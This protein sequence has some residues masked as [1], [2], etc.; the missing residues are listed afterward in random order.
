[1][2]A[3]LLTTSLLIALGLPAHAQTVRPDS[4]SADTATVW[5]SLLE[6]SCLSLDLPPE[7]E[8]FGVAGR[9][10]L[11][12][13]VDTTGRVEPQSLRLIST[14]HPSL[15]R[16]AAL[17]VLNCRY[18]PGRVGHHKERMQV[19]QPIDFHSGAP[20]SGRSDRPPPN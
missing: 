15:T 11:E 13:I 2:R 4:A 3:T 6:G 17:A 1:M 7:A 20:G 19:Q 18:R 14:A 10:I 16:P 12:F 9:V 8:R 5:P